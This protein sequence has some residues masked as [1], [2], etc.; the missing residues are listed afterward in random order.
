M[1]CRF[2][3]SGRLIC[4]CAVGMYA[5]CAAALPRCWRGLFEFT[6][7]GLEYSR[8]TEGVTAGG[9]LTAESL[10]N[11]SSDKVARLSK[12]MRYNTLTTRLTGLWSL[13]LQ[14]NLGYVCH[15]PYIIHYVSII[16]LA[17]IFISKVPTNYLVNLHIMRF[18]IYI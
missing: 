11:V 14:V 5:R 13:N 18:D 10:L 7:I 6:S 4:L 12:Y 1:R 9:L 15:Q 8:F 3:R 16:I 2:W 17:L